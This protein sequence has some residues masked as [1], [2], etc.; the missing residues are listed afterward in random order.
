MS[1]QIEGIDFAV[2]AYREEGE[3]QVVELVH[4]V[5]TDVERLAAALRRFPGDGGAIG[6]VAIDEDFFLIVRVAGPA[7]ASCCPTSPPPTSGSSRARRS[8]FWGCPEPLDEDE[9]GPR[10]ETSTSWATSAWGRWTW[11]CCSTTSTSTPTRCSPT[12]PGAQASGRSSTR[13]SASPQPDHD[14]VVRRGDARRAG[15]GAHGGRIGRRTDRCCRARPHGLGDRLVGTTSASATATRPAT[16]SWSRSGP[17]RPPGGVAADRLHPRRDPR[18]LH[19]VRRRDR[20]LPVD[21]LVFGAYDE[22]AGAV[23]SLWDVVRDRRLNHRPEVVGGVLAD[24]CRMPLDDFF[25]HQRLG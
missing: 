19:D 18:A 4:D 7:Y 25:A 23:G 14:G 12:W 3:W 21:R 8:T 17:P 5:L 16:P 15:R 9:P 22:K 13:P 1:E 2:A 6:L 11:P 24:E 20:P 10:P